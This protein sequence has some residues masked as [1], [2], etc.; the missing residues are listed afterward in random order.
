[1]KQDLKRHGMGTT[2]MGHKKFTIAAVNTVIESDMVVVVISVK[3]KVKFAK[4]ESI[5]FLC[6]TFGFLALSD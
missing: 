3:S 4:E 1:V 5:S 2:M 6:V